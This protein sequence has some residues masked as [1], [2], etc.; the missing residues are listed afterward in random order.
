MIRAL[1]LL[2][3]AGTLALATPAVAQ[4][5]TVGPYE[6]SSEAFFADSAS[7]TGIPRFCPFDQYYPFNIDDLEEVVT[8]YTPGSAFNNLGTIDDMLCTQN[9]QELELGFDDIHAFEAHGPDIILFD[10]RSSADDFAIQVKPIG[11]KFGK[12]HIYPA[13]EHV[14]AITQTIPCVLQLWGVEIDLANHDLPLGTEVDR[15]K[16]IADCN[17]LPTASQYDVVM[18]AVVDRTCESNAECADQDDCTLDACVDG[19]CAYEIA[20]A[21]TVCP[22]GVCVGD[23]TLACVECLVDSQCASPTPFCDPAQQQ[24]VECASDAHCE[25]ALPYCWPVANVCVECTGNE[26]C[27]S[28]DACT[29][30][31]CI[32][33]ECEVEPEPAGTPCDAGVCNGDDAMPSCVDC[34]VDADCSTPTPACDAESASCVACLADDDCDDGDACTT[35]LCNANACAHEA[36]QDCGGQ[37]G[38][39]TGGGG[40]GDGGSGGEPSDAPTDGCSCATGRGGPGDM[41]AGAAAWVLLVIGAWTTRRRERS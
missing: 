33:V 21:G 26:Q 36:V 35:D 9:G 11:G 1:F 40:A 12:M 8:G 34:L 7:M 30:G 18:A 20:P 39:A 28:A 31:A 13:T 4:P 5:I 22:T 25:G 10:V 15:I 38:G 32:G 17:I 16:I 41:P 37:G 29:I 19:T 24:C 6:F 14:F 27:A 3:F 23:S 2:P